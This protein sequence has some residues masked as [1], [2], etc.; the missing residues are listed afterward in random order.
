[1]PHQSQPKPE[2]LCS[3]CVHLQTSLASSPVTQARRSAISALAQL[4]QDAEPSPW[5]R[6][7][8]LPSSP[9]KLRARFHPADRCDK[10]RK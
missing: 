8:G 9:V 1:M 4:S 7:L 5:R 2:A 3:L 6:S 10:G